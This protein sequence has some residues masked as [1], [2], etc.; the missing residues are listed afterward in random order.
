MAKSL[1][2][3]GPDVVL[4]KRPTRIDSKKEFNKKMDDIMSMM[5]KLRNCGPHS[6]SASEGKIRV[7]ELGLF[8]KSAAEEAAMFGGRE[9]GL[10]DDGIHLGQEGS[11]GR[12]PIKKFFSSFYT[13]S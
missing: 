3:K 13:F 1:A 4:L 6:N 2:E 10:P 9:N 7:A 11:K 8:A 5:V 12:S